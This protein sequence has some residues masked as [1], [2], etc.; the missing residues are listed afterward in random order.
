MKSIYPGTFDP[1]TVGHLDIIK[2]A[3]ETCGE[4]VV[5][6]GH[7]PDKT[8]TMFDLETRKR[9]IE[10]ATK[11]FENVTVEHFSGLLV[12]YCNSV[13]SKT[14]VRGF[15][16]VSDVEYELAVGYANESLDDSINTVFFM[17]KV[18]NSFISSSTFRAIH[19][20]GG[21]ASHLVHPSTMDIIKFEDELNNETL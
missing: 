9:M 1:I 10:E 21:D 13:G 20:E 15:R 2:K 12:D 5:A 16:A 17:P 8:N 6:I 3:A 18:K 19:K 4:I 14:I 11:E 7:N